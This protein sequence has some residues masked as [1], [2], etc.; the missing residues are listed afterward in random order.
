MARWFRLLSVKNG[1]TLVS[2]LSG[3]P[4]DTTEFDYHGE[5]PVLIPSGWVNRPYPWHPDTVELAVHRIGDF[6]ILC[7]L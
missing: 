3:S 5:K 6:F 7:E 2:L 4:I 1:L